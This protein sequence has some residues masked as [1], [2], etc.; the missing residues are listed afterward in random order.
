MS[1]GN[2]KT[3]SGLG[4]YR[5]RFWYAWQLGLTGVGWW[6]YAHHGGADRW[7]GPNP[8]GDY[9]ATVYDGQRGPVSSKRWEAAREGIEDY[10]Y[11]CMLRDGIRAAES[12]GVDDA[13]LAAAKR[14]FDELPKRIEPLLLGTGRRL[15]LTPDSVP[16]YKQATDS[17]EAA[18]SE[19]VGACMAL[20]MLR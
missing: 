15:P 2:S 1:D 19:I 14:L 9:F 8:T 17:I 5:W 16:A 6:V 20:K 13:Q 3:L 4:F 11:L 12:R 7:D 18:R 10:E